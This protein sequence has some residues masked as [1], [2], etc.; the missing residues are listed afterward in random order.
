MPGWGTTRDGLRASL[1]GIGAD[2]LVADVVDPDDVV[3]SIRRALRGELVVAPAMAS[4]LSLLLGAPHGRESGNRA[5]T[6]RELEILEHLLRQATAQTFRARCAGL[7]LTGLQEHFTG[8]ETVESA[9]PGRCRPVPLGAPGVTPPVP[10]RTPAA[11]SVAGPRLG[12]RCVLLRPRLP[13]CARETHVPPVPLPGRRHQTTKPTTAKVSPPPTSYTKP[14]RSGGDG[15][16]STG[17]A[18][19]IAPPRR[20]LGPWLPDQERGSAGLSST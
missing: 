5:L 18:R 15:S 13:R 20:A 12:R 4:K 10:V 17:P 11:G 8:G 3:D 16:P 7:D 19:W 6:E 2:E 14:M 9:T 1:S